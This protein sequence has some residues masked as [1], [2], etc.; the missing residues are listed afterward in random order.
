MK[1][2]WHHIVCHIAIPFVLLATDRLE[3]AGDQR[4]RTCLQTQLR[5]G[6][7]PFSHRMAGAFEL[8]AS[9]RQDL[10]CRTGTL[11]ESAPPIGL[12][13]RE[14]NERSVHWNFVVTTAEDILNWW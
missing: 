2:G 10:N 14:R 1:S 3:T 8:F 9:A 12:V 6:T 5:A 11:E 4:Q 7:L 13:I